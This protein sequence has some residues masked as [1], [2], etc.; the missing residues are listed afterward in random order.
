MMVNEQTPKQKDPEYDQALNDGLFVMVITVHVNLLDLTD[1]NETRLN[2]SIAT[3]RMQTSIV[4][5]AGTRS[6][7]ALPSR[8]LCSPSRL[9]KPADQVV[10][11]RRTRPEHSG[12]EQSAA[13]EPRSRTEAVEQNEKEGN[14]DEF[15]AGLVEV[16]SCL[17]LMKWN[18]LY[19]PILQHKTT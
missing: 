3:F 7:P 11:D 9:A 18:Y 12:H 14:R 6:V 4:L 16:H 5:R 15:V 1:E 10:A 19:Q 2:Y 13:R 8:L 17:R